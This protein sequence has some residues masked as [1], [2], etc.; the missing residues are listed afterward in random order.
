MP[1]TSSPAPSSSRLTNRSSAIDG[2]SAQC[3]SSR[4][5]SSGR[6]AAAVRKKPVTLSNNRKRA[7]SGS[8]SGGV[9]RSGRRSRIAGTIWAMSAAPAPISV[10]SSRRSGC[11]R[12]PPGPRAQKAEA[13]SPSQQ[14]PHS[15]R[16]PCAVAWAANSSA[17]R[18]LPMPGSPATSTTPP[19]PAA[20]LSRSAVSAASSAS[21]PTNGVVTRTAS[22][23]E[24]LL[25]SASR[26]RAGRSRR[27][28]DPCRAGRRVRSRLR[29][30]PPS[31]AIQQPGLAHASW[32]VQ[33]E[34]RTRWF[35]R[36]K[37][38]PEEL[39]FGCAPDDPAP[40]TRRQQA[41]AEAAGSPHLG[42]SGRIRAEVRN[43]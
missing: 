8:T 18:V 17:S 22:P 1:T 33:V 25:R 4:I 41:A 36:V 11:R 14:R 32:P 27:Q 40:P 26:Y 20:A 10:P 38:G 16:A 39:G 30:R 2:I 35:G 37:R 5:S 42:H 9:G 43:F 34:H 23:T 13:P 19:R 24:P 31:Q 6:W 7:A 15:T 3:K 21:R 12:A 28:A 29:Q